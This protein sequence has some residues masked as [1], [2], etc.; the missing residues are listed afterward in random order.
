MIY[1][2]VSANHDEE[3]TEYVS[4][5]LGVLRRLAYLLC[6]DPHR[7]DDLVQ[8]AITRLYS[9][10]ERAWAVE[11]LDAY[12]RTILV[13]VYLKDRQSPWAMRIRLPGELPEPEPR[14][15]DREGGL[16]VRAALAAL[17]RG[18]RATLVLRFYIDLSVDEAARA[19]SCSPGTVKSQTAKGLGSLRRALSQPP[20]T[21]PVA[22]ARPMPPMP[23]TQNPT[24]V[25]SNG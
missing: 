10:W 16:D 20:G 4:A 17:P 5:N 12:T 14:T 23:A 22:P 24:G 3:F 9:H 11:N 6:Q 25:E 18:Q 13:R 7:V 21:R 15:E 19:L 2:G 8:T 1:V